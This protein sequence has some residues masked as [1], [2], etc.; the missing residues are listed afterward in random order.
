MTEAT[1]KIV[2]GLGARACVLPMSD[3]PV[4]T[5][6]LVDARWLAFQD[7]FVRRRHQDVVTAVK[8]EGVDRA[9][10]THEFIQAIARAEI[11]VLVNS[12]PV[13]S[14]LPIISLPGVREALQRASA[15]RLAVSPI[16]GDDAVTGPAGRLMKL[17]GQ[18]ASATG[19]ARTY[20]GL[21]HGIVID[22]KDA[23]QA[24]EI[25]GMG[26]RVLATETVMRDQADQE[27]LAR[28]TLD[29]ARALR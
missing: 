19:V 14:I 12:N 26:I 23:G 17:I 7:Y 1:Q 10:P 11:I 8:Y 13:L 6:L 28:E 20:D 18:P 27:R 15:S 29:F 4:A 2:Q 3:D 5:R 16:V 25:E 9:H 22:Q 24:S 21:I